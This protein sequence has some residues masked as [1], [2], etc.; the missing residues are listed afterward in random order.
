ML[1]VVHH[2]PIKYSRESLEKILAI[3]H[4]YTIECRV[5]EGDFSPDEK[6]E[7]HLEMLKD[8]VYDPYDWI[9]YADM[10]EFQDWE[11]PAKYAKTES[12]EI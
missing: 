12:E 10:N 9:I 4:G 11:G 8:F 3:C 6:Y 7:Q 5:W 1:V 2:S